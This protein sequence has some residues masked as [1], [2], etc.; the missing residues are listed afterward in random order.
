MVSSATAAGWSAPV[1]PTDADPVADEPGGGTAVLRLLPDTTD[2]T[3]VSGTVTV[4]PGDSLWSIAADE[5]EA[6][7]GSRPTDREVATYWRRV[8]EVN[9]PSLVDPAN[10]DLIFPGQVMTLPTA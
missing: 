9:R 8:I 3:A 6:V 4:E 10:P 7:R 1:L 2:T 5:L